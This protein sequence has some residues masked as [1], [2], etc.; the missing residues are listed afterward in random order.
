M[1]NKRMFTMKIVD[2]DAF[3]D[4]PLSAQCLYFHF[5]MRADDDGFIGNPKRIMRLLGASEDDLKLLIVKRFLLTFEDGVIVIKHWRMHNTLSKYRYHETQYLDEK[6]M[7]RIKEN[8]SYSFDSGEPI[9]DSK[10][11]EAKKDSGEQKEDNRRTNGEQAENKR[12]T[13]GEQVETTDLDLFLDLD[14]G[15]DKEKKESKER[16]KFVSPS[17]EKVQQYLDSVGS[18]VDAEA[19]VAFYESKG[20]MV[21]KNK[22]KSWKAAIVTWEKRNGLKRTTSIKTNSPP[23]EEKNEEEIIGDDWMSVENEY[24]AIREKENGGD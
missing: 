21:G 24:T 14:K 6:S 18:Q 13:D 2:S 23:E 10:L 4:M 15:I 17:I 20:W 11:L 7:L 22:M 1:A 3:L 19:F 9:D 12:R 8:G 16:K 5:N